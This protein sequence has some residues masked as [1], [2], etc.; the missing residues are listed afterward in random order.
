MHP[1]QLGKLEVGDDQILFEATGDDEE[2]LNLAANIFAQNMEERGFNVNSV[3]VNYGKK[4]VATPSHV[5]QLDKIS[6]VNV[7]APA[8]NSNQP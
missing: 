5:S 2:S 3:N 1:H 8:I 6:E 7:P 4:T